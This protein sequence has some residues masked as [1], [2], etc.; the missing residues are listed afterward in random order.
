MLCIF[1]VTQPLFLGQ[2][3]SYYSEGEPKAKEIYIYSAAIILCSM[4]NILFMHPFMF[5]IL[6]MGMKMRTAACSM[7]YRKALRLSKTALGEATAGQVVNLLSNDVARLDLAVIFVH[8][9]WVGPLETV[10]VTY[11]MYREVS[12][13][14][15]IY[16]ELYEV[17]FDL[18]R[19]V[20]QRLWV[21]HSS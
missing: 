17:K 9:L 3:I 15:F 12:I 7:I 4:G 13:S 11:F 19:L 8:Y 18:F 21:L 14:L 5:E 1:R 10:V 2:L 20:L 16:Y 6:H